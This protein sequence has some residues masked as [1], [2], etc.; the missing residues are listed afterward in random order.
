MNQEKFLKNKI[1][2]QINQNGSFYTFNRFGVDE[3]EQKTDE[4]EE[5]FEVHGLF[6]ETVKHVAITESDAARIVDVPKSYILCLFDDGDLIKVDDFVEIN[7]NLYRVTGKI[8]V[9]NFN[10]AYDISLEMEVD[11]SKI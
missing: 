6:H 11:G 3:Y 7:N 9:G 8:N 5:T 1:N 10:V 2:R 4:V